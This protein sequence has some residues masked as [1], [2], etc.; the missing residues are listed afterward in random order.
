MINVEYNRKENKTVVTLNK[1]TLFRP[2]DLPLTAHFRKTITNEEVWSSELAPGT[3]VSWGGAET[4]YNVVLTTKNGRTVFE[5]KYS[6]AQHG[7]TIEKVMWYF[8]RSLNHRP[9]GLVIGCHDGTFGHWTFPLIAGLTDAVLVDGSKPQ[10]D[11]A[12]KN[13][14]HLPF[15]KFVHDIVTT[16]GSEVEWFEGGEGFTDT[17]YKPVINVFLTDDK[18]TQT[19]R[20]STSINDLIEKNSLQNLDWLHLDVEGIDGDLILA[21]KYEP[22]LIIFEVMHIKQ[23]QYY[24]ILDWAQEHNYKLFNDGSNAIMLKNNYEA[25]QTGS[26]K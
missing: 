20:T 23:E 2:E 16:D 15:V 17:I 13:Y 5:H 26:T 4:P 6:V 19:H 22:T 9:S 8:I 12:V 3:W 7:D 21:L 25:W 24:A 18:I 10:F 1:F 14:G 11:Q